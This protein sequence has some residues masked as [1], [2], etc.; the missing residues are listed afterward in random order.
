[1]F[2][3]PVSIVDM[4]GVS[5]CISAIG[6]ASALWRSACGVEVKVAKVDVTIQLSVGVLLSRKIRSHE[7][8]Q[9]Q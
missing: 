5:M 1:M 8:K 3:H 9:E 2:G 4:R 6:E 7:K